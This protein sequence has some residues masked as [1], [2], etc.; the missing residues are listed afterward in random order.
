[1]DAAL[2]T[3]EA[4][5]THKIFETNSSFDDGCYNVKTLIS[6]FQELSSSIN[7]I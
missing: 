5:I 3:L 2:S 1:M 6:V 7:N 4:A